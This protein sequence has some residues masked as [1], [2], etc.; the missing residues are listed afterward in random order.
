[1][2]LSLNYE[3]I[4]ISSGGIK[5]IY[6]VGIITHLNDYFPIH[7]IKYYTGCSVGALICVLINIGY[8]INE[9]NKIIFEINFEIFQDLKIVNLLDKC[10]LDEGIKF[11]NFLKAI[12][13]N[14]NLNQDITFKELHDITNK[15][16]TIVVTNI[17]T[18]KAE[19]HNYMT[20]PNLSILL[21]LRMSVNIPIIFSPI[22]YNNNYYVDGA[23]LDPF[24]YLYNKNIDKS[25]KIGLLLFSNYELNFIKNSDI[26][27][28]NNIT[29]SFN[30]TFQL[31]KI[32]HINYIKNFYKKIPKNVIYIKYELE[33]S[34]AFFNL[35]YEEKKRMHDVGVL[36]CKKFLKKI[37]MAKE[38]IFLKKKY[39]HL[40]RFLNSV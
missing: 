16:L 7:K 37:F 34:Q 20:T 27:F 35:S 4:I 22:S 39:F 25:R 28:V 18:G 12:I 38:K 6:F 8:S 14:K 19:Y 9:I 40:L 30:Y 2:N 26:H 24:P 21:S 36:E 31:L 15:V 17:T 33:N 5:G 10:G 1:M 32:I 29:N 23:L 11:T 13:I 3:E